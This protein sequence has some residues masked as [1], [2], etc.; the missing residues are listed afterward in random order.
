MSLLPCQIQL[1][2]EISGASPLPGR[3]ATPAQV[4]DSLFQ[5]LIDD[6]GGQAGDSRSIFSGTDVASWFQSPRC[7]ESESKGGED[8]LQQLLKGLR[9][10]GLPAGGL[11]LSESSAAAVARMLEHK[12]FSQEEIDRLLRSAA[13]KDGLIRLDT[14]MARLDH[15]G[16]A[17]K[18]TSSGLV[19]SRSDIPRVQEMLFKMGLGVDQ[20]KEAVEKSMGR[21]GDLALDRLAGTL[22]GFFKE[23]GP[24][25]A[26]RL[27][28]ILEREMGV[29]L[30]NASLE[31][32]L[33]Q[34]G[35]D[36]LASRLHRATQEGAGYE[37][38]KEISALLR[39]KEIQPQEIKR[40]LET[41]EA[42][43]I[44]LPNR[45]ST[46]SAETL[47]LLQKERSR[48]RPDGWK[49]R[50][51]EILNKENFKTAREADPAAQKGVSRAESSA[52]FEK[53]VL[54]VKDQGRRAA[55]GQDPSS[56]LRPGTDESRQDK[57][58]GS[59]HAALKVEARPKT[60]EIPAF[61]NTSS[62]EFAVHR[63]ERPAQTEPG[64]RTAATAPP[65][66][67]PLPKIVDRIVLMVRAGEQHA[68][69]HISPPDLGR[70]D[71]DLVIKNGHLHAHLG[72]EN[73]AAKELLEAN[74]QQLRQQLN[75]L[76][77][78]VERFEVGVGL[79]ERRGAEADGWGG[80]KGRRGAG[81]R[82]G[83]SDAAGDIQATKPVR[84]GKHGPYRI[85]VEA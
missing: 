55:P 10:L 20:V 25:T 79:N 77:F 64:A 16:R 23:V 34:A 2:T 38:K 72:A 80:S 49:A 6:L 71:L 26:R 42:K 60:E 19:V 1:P 59:A 9:E 8:I 48:S 31:K 11:M 43:E 67:E 39:E 85:D 36:R 35:L 68:R 56:N 52:L 46:V 37:L 28:G 58:R 4:G 75:G 53:I 66:P 62:G 32:T 47:G 61:R 15:T 63:A 41:L 57:G 74:I 51:L 24:G 69:I 17:G 45:G 27:A 40:F 81:P 83:G 5:R 3:K 30:Q 65:L 73:P 13:D 50:I 76:G 84:M 7:A 54:T 21:S 29:R 82:R 44:R 33:E 70:L 18:E 22:K 14:L 78:V 12:G